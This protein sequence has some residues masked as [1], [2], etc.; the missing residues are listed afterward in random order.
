[1]SRIARVPPLAW[2][3]ALALGAVIFGLG[4][5]LR[6]DGDRWGV[7]DVPTEF[8][9]AAS[10]EDAE[11]T[12]A[13]PEAPSAER[14]SGDLVPAGRAETT[15]EPASTAPIPEFHDPLPPGGVRGTIALVIDDVGR[16]VER[17]D[18]FMAVGVPITFAV[19]PFEPRTAQVVERVQ[20]LGAEMLVHLPMEGAAGANPGPGAL[21]ATMDVET[22]RSRTLSAL[23]AVPGAV[24]VNNH[25]GSVFS[26]D[27]ERMGAVLE[28]VGSRGLF[29]LDS[30]TSANSVGYRL[31]RDL[32]LDAAQR[33]V[34]LDSERE[35]DA[36][37]RQWGELL[38]VAAARGSAI[39]IGHPYDETL[40]VLSRRVEEAEA[41]GFRFVPVSYLLERSGD[42]ES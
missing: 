33:D 8:A 36:I 16:R 20:D 38:T 14:S 5:M 35:I 21:M 19:L 31:A 1:M 3:F 7:A 39:A 23:D 25:M 18:R 37:E 22:L 29:F 41:A 2:A 42:P 40:E 11:T 32:A 9:G 12:P 10:A 30:R 15:T 4:L 34:F 27:A 6:G 17:I 26:A 28:Q 24:G 13:D